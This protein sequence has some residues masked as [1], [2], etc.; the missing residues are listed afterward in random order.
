MELWQDKTF[1][2]W[3]LWNITKFVNLSVAERDF[4]AVNWTQIIQGIWEPATLAPIIE[5]LYL[6]RG[7]AMIPL[8][9]LIGVP[10][11]ASLLGL[12]KVYEDPRLCIL[13]V[14]RIVQWDTKKF[15]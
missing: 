12:N 14:P 2:C 4:P 13:V 11:N 9:P 3:K 10:E 15:C 1:I 7:E 5:A 6:Y 8:K